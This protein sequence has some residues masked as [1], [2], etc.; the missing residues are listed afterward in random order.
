MLNSIEIKN[1]RGIKHLT[2]DNFKNINIFL[3]KA[4]TGKTS[5]IEAIECGITKNINSLILLSYF[6]DEKYRKQI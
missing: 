4:N 5:V 6:R 1:F 2:I 3:G